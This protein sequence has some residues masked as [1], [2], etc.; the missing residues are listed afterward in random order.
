MTAIMGLNDYL[1]N[2]LTP[3]KIVVSL[4]SLGLAALAARLALG[5][6][7]QAYLD[8][9]YPPQKAADP[10]GQEILQEI[11]DQEKRRIA[12]I[13][14]KVAARL[15]QAKQ[16]GFDVSALEAKADTALGLAGVP[17]SRVQAVRMLGEVE[18]AV[19]RKAIEA[20]QP[21]PA[22]EGEIADPIP[23][24]IKTR[25]VVRRRRSRR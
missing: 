21:A 15:A 20:V 14:R 3:R 25:R 16:E 11:A 22:P 18:L 7:R 17:S 24:K 19:P 10:A 8:W 1:F 9:R 23:K 6:G 5:P 12:A 13:H 4:L 2:N